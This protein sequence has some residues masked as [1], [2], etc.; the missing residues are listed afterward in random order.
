MKH[1]LKQFYL[2]HPLAMVFNGKCDGRG[3]DVKNIDKDKK[4][5]STFYSINCYWTRICW[6]SVV[7]K[8]QWKKHLQ[9]FSNIFVSFYDFG[10]SFFSL[11]LSPEWERKQH[12]ISNI[13]LHVYNIH[14]RMVIT[15]SWLKYEP[16]TPF[17]NQVHYGP[18]DL[19]HLSQARYHYIT[20]PFCV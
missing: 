15:S 10:L 12:Q 1:I 20:S 5:L 4:I 13:D 8:S 14:A 11:S 7:L 19:P 9:T 17:Y 2:W 6:F 3:C 16:K 18:R